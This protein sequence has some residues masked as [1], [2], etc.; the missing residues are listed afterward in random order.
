MPPGGPAERS[1]PEKAPRKR[2]YS[3]KPG[4]VGPR[5]TH[6]QEKKGMALPLLPGYTDGQYD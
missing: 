6:T 5:P 4:P 3:G 1:E 2:A